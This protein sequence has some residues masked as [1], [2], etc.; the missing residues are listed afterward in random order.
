MA[1][2]VCYKLNTPII[3]NKGTKHES[4]CDTFLAYYYRGTR[5][6]TQA[7]VDKLNTEKP[8]RLF[9]GELALCEERIYFV[10]EQ[11]EMY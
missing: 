8:E 10:N 2:T 11:D 3:Y 9:N 7:H 6:Q 4:S 1:M 5:E